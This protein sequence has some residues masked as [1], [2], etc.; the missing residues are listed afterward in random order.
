MSEDTLHDDAVSEDVYAAQ[1][2]E[3]RKAPNAASVQP[4]TS[5]L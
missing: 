2:A 4:S 1:L 3:F 5:I